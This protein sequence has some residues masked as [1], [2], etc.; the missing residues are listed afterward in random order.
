[1][2]NNELMHY[3]VLGMK[4][5]HRRAQRLLTKAA[6]KRDSA[7]ELNNMSS[8]KASQ[9]KS[10]SALK[11]HNKAEAAQYKAERYQEK[12]KA[13]T[14][15]HMMRSG[16][17]KAYDYGTKQSL[18]K[19]LVKTYLMGTYGTLRYNELKSKGVS[20]GKSFL[21]GVGLNSINMLSLGGVGFIEPRARKILYKN[22]S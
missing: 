20:R 10:K 17:K 6:K 13:I 9:G 12:S 5:G 19:T 2:N 18:G 16:G 22:R 4:W 11:K 1:M 21:A 3:G 7:R 8:Y 14:K 15:K